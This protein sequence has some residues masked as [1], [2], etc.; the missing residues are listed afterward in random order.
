MYGKDLTPEVGY[1]C[2]VHWSN[3]S[4]GYFP[5][6]T[7]G[8]MTAAQFFGKCK[9]DNPQMMNEIGNGKFSTLVTWLRENVHSKGCLYT[10]DELVENVTGKKLDLEIF[11]DYLKN[12][13]L[14]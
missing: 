10:A 8:A 9:K 12:K 6:Y 1:A 11:K 7:L 4:F 5:T 13:Y 2:D 14:N 3:G